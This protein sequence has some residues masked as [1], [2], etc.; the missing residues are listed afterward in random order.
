MELTTTYAPVPGEKVPGGAPIALRTGSL[1]DIDLLCE[2]DRDATVL[3]ERAGLRLDFPSDHEFALAERNRWLQ[4]LAAGT[5]LIA[6]DRSASAIG[7]AA[8]AVLDGEP[9][10]DQLSVRQASMGQGIG[11][12]L[13]H[14][15]AGMIRAAGGTA[16]WLI[17]YNHLRWNRTFYERHGFVI[18]SYERAGLELRGELL[19]QQRWLPM[20]HE[21]VVMRKDLLSD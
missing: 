19:Y 18:V 14:S 5:V 3:L 7:F 8:L 11:T 4:C 15:S 13:L 21:R 20:P 12:A 9:F 17:T 10:L 2:I 1:A 16:I 6:V